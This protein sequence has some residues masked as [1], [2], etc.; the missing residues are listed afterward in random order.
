MFFPLKRHKQHFDL[1]CVLVQTSREK[2]WI[3][4]KI[5]TAGLKEGM[6]NFSSKKMF[7]RKWWDEGTQEESRQVSSRPLGTHSDFPPMLPKWCSKLLVVRTVTLQ[8]VTQ[9]ETPKLNNSQPISLQPPWMYL[10]HHT[11]SV[12]KVNP[13]LALMGLYLFGS[14]ESC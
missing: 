5:S 7:Y 6:E 12:T 10:F 4:P 11:L 13:T 9:T 1:I 8:G 2:R 3:P 14:H